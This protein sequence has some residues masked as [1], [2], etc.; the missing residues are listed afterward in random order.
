MNLSDFILF[1]IFNH[2]VY[3]WLN[4]VK[5]YFDKCI[6]MKKSLDLCKYKNISL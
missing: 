5:N 3:Y 4:F 6:I 2:I 1:F